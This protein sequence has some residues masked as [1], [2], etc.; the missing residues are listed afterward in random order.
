[1]GARGP[2]KDPM[3]PTFTFFAACAAQGVIPK[4]KRNIPTSNTTE[5]FFIRQLLSVI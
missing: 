5:N 3:C 4:P 2:V 1:M